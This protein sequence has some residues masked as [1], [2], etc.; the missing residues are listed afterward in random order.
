MTPHTLFLACLFVTILFVTTSKSL[1]NYHQQPTS[2]IQQLL[3]SG[4]QKALPATTPTTNTVCQGTHGVVWHPSVPLLLYNRWKLKQCTNKFGKSHP[5]YTIHRNGTKTI[6][7]HE[8][9]VFYRMGDMILGNDFCG[10]CQRW[11]GTLA[12][13]YLRTAPVESV[14]NHHVEVQVLKLL[15]NKLLL[16]LVNDPDLIQGMAKNTIVMHLRIGDALTED[17]CF[18][19]QCTAGGIHYA[20]DVTQMKKVVAQI[21][22]MNEQKQRDTWQTTRVEG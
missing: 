19:K 2:S 10:G 13:A 17:D 8:A 9:W 7:S 21:L 15:T 20:V 14:L 12:C 5:L 16:N 22:E 4:L 11:P 18:H 3:R 6:H 1:T